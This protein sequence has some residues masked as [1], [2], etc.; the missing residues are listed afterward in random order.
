M[1]LSTYKVESGIDW[2]RVYG[3]ILAGGQSS[4]LFPFNKVLSD[5]TGQGR[6]LLQQAADRLTKIFRKGPHAGFISSQKIYV[7]TTPGF[8]LPMSRQLRLPSSHFFIDPA[9]R[10]TWPAILWAMAHIGLKDA[11]ATLAVTTSDHIIPH[12]EAFRKGAAQA[13]RL[14]QEKPAL[15]VL[16]VKPSSDPQDWLGFGSFKMEGRPVAARP[17]VISGFEEKPSLER[18]HQ[19][20]RE[21][22]WQWNAGMFFFSIST[23]ERALERLQPAMYEIYATMQME[24]RKGNIAKAKK[25]FERFPSKIPHPLKPECEAD[26]TIDYAMAAPL[27]RDPIDPLAVYG[28]PGALPEW[29]DLGRWDVLRTLVPR[30]SHGNVRVGHIKAG[31]SVRNCILVADQG[32]WMEV[33]GLQDSVAAFSSGRALVL[34]VAELGRVK[35]LVAEADGRSVVAPGLPAGSVSLTRNRLRVVVPPFRHSRGL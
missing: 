32:C 14:A 17:R 4:R 34:P 23:A 1:K 19:M 9:R 24:L 3:L 30:D 15:V 31:R 11:E 22:G 27:V 21:G 29:T 7:L 13:I 20:I 25:I 10:G 2:N 5:L 28:V 6:T 12:V 8:V 16:A 33:S 26:N 18:A 35:E